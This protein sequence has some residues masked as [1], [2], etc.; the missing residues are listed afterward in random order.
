MTIADF[1][2][3]LRGLGPDAVVKVLGT[4]YCGKSSAFGFGDRLQN[5]DAVAHEY[6][7]KCPTQAAHAAWWIDQNIEEAVQITGM[8]PD[9]LK[10]MGRHL[11]GTNRA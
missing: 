5:G 7:R 2:D 3:T 8:H 6:M 1:A 4:V 9:S 11:M 10:L